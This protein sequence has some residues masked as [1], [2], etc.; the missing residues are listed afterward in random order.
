MESPRS[1]DGSTG[2][3]RSVEQ[4]CE[5]E[6]VR[7]VST[8]LTEEVIGVTRKRER[9]GKGAGA[10]ASLLSLHLS[11]RQI[12]AT[13][14]D[15]LPTSCITCEHEDRDG[16][17][18]S[19]VSSEGDGSRISSE[20]VDLA[21]DP[22]KSLDLVAQPEV[23]HDVDVV[24]RQESCASAADGMRALLASSLATASLLDPAIYPR[25][26]AGSSG[27]RG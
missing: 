16:N 25:L 3:Y 8:S 2:G 23:P 27:Q 18:S 4:T 12:P 5:R 11:G 7:A 21:A 10:A 19:V 24:G 1:E 6:D 17:G 15:P 9:G 13:D 22:S 26:P 20:G 14:G